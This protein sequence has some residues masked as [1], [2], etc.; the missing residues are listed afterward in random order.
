MKP[1]VLTI[2]AFGPY[3]GTQI[4]DFSELK[5]RTFFLIHGPTGA[6]KTTILDAICF[7]LYGDASGANR[8]GKTMRSDHADPTAST[9]VLFDFS[10]G[11]ACYRVQ[12]IPEQE[13]QKKR[14][15][16]TTVQ[17]AEA[18]LWSLAP[19]EE[20]TVL[21][22]GWS[23]V[24]EQVE[25][26]LNFKSSQFR[27]VV[28][29]PQGDFRK[30]LLADSKQRQEILQVLFKTELYQAVE[31]QLKTK[32]QELS[33]G[34]EELNKEYRWIL[35]E[36]GVQSAPELLEEHAINNKMLTSFTAQIDQLQEQLDQAQERVTQGNIIWG[37]LLEQE[38]AGAALADLNAQ[39]SAVEESRVKWTQANRA[40]GLFDAEKTVTQLT[41]DVETAHTQQG[42]CEVALKAVEQELAL[43]KQH[44]KEKQEQE[45][46]RERISQ[47]IYKL[48]EL[49]GKAEA[50][51]K[52]MELL[53]KQAE[54][55]DAAAHRWRVAEQGLQELR[56]RLD[57]GNTE[58]QRVL[59][60]A[61]QQQVYQ[62][63]LEQWQQVAEK[64]QAL[65]ALQARCQVADEKLHELT[66]LK[67]QKIAACS[68]AHSQYRQV[69]QR[70]VE[71]QAAVL[72]T[73]LIAGMPCPVCG[74][75]EHPAKAAGLGEVPTE[76][77]VRLQ[78]ERVEK[79]EAEQQ[80]VVIQLIESQKD[81]ENVT[82]RIAELEQE[83]GAYACMNRTEMQT[84]ERTAAEN[85]RLAKQAGEQVSALT[86]QLADWKKQAQALESE[87]KTLEEC[88]RWAE[89]TYQSTH[90]LTKE[91]QAVIPAAYHDAN[92]LYHDIQAAEIWLAESKLSCTAAQQKAEQIGQLLSSKQAA[93]FHA[94]EL[95]QKSHTRLQE[96]QT[97][98][99][100]RL[101]EADFRDMQ[102]YAEA[103]SSFSQIQK[104]EQHIRIFD[105][106]LLAAKER[107][108]RAEAAAQNLQRPDLTALRETHL[109]L[110]EQHKIAVQDRAVLASKA[111]RQT[112]WLEKIAQLRQELDKVEIRYGLIGRLA[113]VANGRNEYGLT[114]QRFVLGALLDDVVIAA[115]E[116]LKMMSRSRYYLQRTMDRA[117]KN[118]AGG[119]DLEV[120]DHYTGVA[121][122]V[123]TL[124]GGETFLASL[125]LALGLADVVQAYAGGIHLDAIFVDEGFG[126]LDPE[127][128]DFAIKALL[129]L[130]RN[131]RMVGIISHVPELKERIDARLEIR[132]SDRGSMA[133]FYL[134]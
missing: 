127:T 95:Y 117:R 98:F 9:E 38:Q 29:L 128:L 102:E 82:G 104:L 31:E 126:T 81:R 6:G 25:Q 52:D 46:E 94:T 106:S 8:D 44:L 3:A 134:G 32:A 60:I 10:V 49:L 22:T 41:A 118:A 109:Q 129:D 19:G 21:A 114:F 37:R 54:E 120:F 39:I 47:R 130:Q 78:R 86:L 26:L 12:R 59:Q 40:A 34:F 36:A 23:K 101:A 97:L 87:V 132:T 14:G 88:Y 33:K 16:G 64:K 42:D 72:A 85:H 91:R 112:Q 90:T 124:S 77:Q 107:V 11:I 56:G 2:R 58:Y 5:D 57:A 45:C 15:E 99:M 69:Q 61:T 18:T 116:R 66:K 62:V 7:A 73:G 111:Q 108:A 71:G 53:R 79:L 67:Q 84:M 75:L 70:W 43:A 68:A 24:T 48:R 123:N 110:Q 125:S 20:L 89:N 35:L 93:V 113:E 100:G 92:V 119:L 80:R 96:E 65:E 4:I 121:R 1:L 131:G 17:T 74:G 30:L 76:E 50:L 105:S 51:E 115:N 63:A 133:K 28:L 13:R 55:R 103:K 122:G 83:L 27:Q